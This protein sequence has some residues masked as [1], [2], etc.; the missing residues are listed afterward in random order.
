[1]IWR[2]KMKMRALILA[3]VAVLFFAPSVYC[4][5]LDDLLK[6]GSEFPLSSSRPSSSNEPDQKTTISGLKEALSV[7]TEKAVGLVSK[8]DGYF[9]NELIKILL[10][11][12]V[13]RAADM[14]SKLG[15]QKQV[16]DLI[17]AMNRAA[18]AAAPK[19][20]AMFVQAI[21]EMS[22]DDARRILQGSNTAATEYFKGKTND[23]LYTE[24]KPVVTS[25][26]N[27]VGVAKAYKNFMTPVQ[28]L[29]LGSKDSMDLDH[30]VTNKALDGLFFM[31]AEEE[32]R[33]RTD[34]AAR[35]T[36]LLKKVFGK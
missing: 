6:K 14:I 17:L 35:V 26:M 16:D 18:E 7:G 24:F 28:S 9:R 29:P 1:M 10:P 23:K 8:Q 30:Y 36:D 3:V 5:P 11:E 19:A 15:Y 33:I 31:V 20:K 12:N 21:K 4:G 32:K 13:Q 2:Q 27:K 34:P 22:F 25:S